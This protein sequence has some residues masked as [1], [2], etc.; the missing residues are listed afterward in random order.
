[1]GTIFF[2]I[3]GIFLGCMFAEQFEIYSVWYF[4]ALLG[5]F[6]GIALR[7]VITETRKW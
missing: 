3:V 7:K 2:C 1:M 4:V 6:G 5:V